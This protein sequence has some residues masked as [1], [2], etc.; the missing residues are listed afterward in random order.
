[1]RP[2][3]KP[4]AEAEVRFR[5]ASPGEF[6]HRI[7]RAAGAF[8]SRYAFAD[9]VLR[10]PGEPGAPDAGT[11]RVRR[12]RRP[13][14]E[15]ALLLSAT[16]A[17]R[18]GGAT[19]YRSRL[20]GGKVQLYQGSLRDCLRVARALGFQPAF[21]VDHTRGEL[22]KLPGGAEVVLERIR[23]S[24][25]GRRV[26]LGWWAEVAAR[27]R[28]VED[29]RRRLRAALRRLG[30]DDSAAAAASLPEAVASALRT[31]GGREGG[32]EPTGSK[33]GRRKRP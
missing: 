2:P 6:R 20:P 14:S 22:W 30:L 31:G 1:M 7:Q 28:S 17:R 5:V 24:G 29:A 8:V 9:T 19:V 25:G 21:R 26:E 15:C 13:R 33:P 12:Y 16:P 10:P 32:V 18:A 23:G 4:E 11:L 27:G 3:R